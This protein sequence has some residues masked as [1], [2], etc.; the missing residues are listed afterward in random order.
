MSTWQ[1]DI[2]LLATQWRT[3]DLLK[4]FWFDRIG[5]IIGLFLHKEIMTSKL[6]KIIIIGIVLVVLALLGSVYFN[7]W[8]KQKMQKVQLGLSEPNFPYK[9]YTQEELNKMYPQIKYADV[10]TRITPEQ[11]Y[12]KFRQA[13][14]END[15]EMAIEQLSAESEKYEENARIL[16][17]AYQQG[18]FLEIYQSYPEKIEKSN[19]Y[20][21]IAEY[22]Y[23][24]KKG[25]YNLRQSINFIKDANGDWKLD[26][27]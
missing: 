15:L 8:F 3:S 17:D 5:N 18:K 20:E 21:S 26:S 25:E 6:K 13:L 23:L 19:M 7:T 10:E 1:V 4:C 12:E 2:I 24:E 14:Q 27:L 22:Y 16:T 11:T 9:D